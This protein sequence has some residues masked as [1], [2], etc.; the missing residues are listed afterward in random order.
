MF[1]RL[2]ISLN[3]KIYA[4]LIRFLYKTTNLYEDYLFYSIFIFVF[5]EFFILTGYFIRIELAKTSG[6]SF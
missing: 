3:F 2:Q 5:S 6:A 1:Q 4:N